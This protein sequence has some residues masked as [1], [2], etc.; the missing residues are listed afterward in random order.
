MKSLVLLVAG[1]V[2]LSSFTYNNENIKKKENSKLV[3][4]QTWKALCANGS[5]GGMFDCDCTQSQA[6]A[7]AYIMC[8]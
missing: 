3:K 6:N 5:V 7:I 8:N 4:M 1:I 2:T